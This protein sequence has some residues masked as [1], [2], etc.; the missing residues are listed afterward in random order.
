MRIEGD[1][2]SGIDVGPG[3]RPTEVTVVQLVAGTGPPVRDQSLVTVDFLAQEWG[4]P[5]PFESTYFKDPVVVPVGTAGSLPA[6]DRA[7]IG[8]PQGSRVL[9]TAPSTEAQVPDSAG[10]GEHATIAWVID[11]LG[12]S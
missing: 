11:I 8:L 6:W 2:P 9:V 5:E 3:T 12:V 7:L 1:L 4:S 10:I